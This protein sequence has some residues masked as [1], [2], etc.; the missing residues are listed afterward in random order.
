M[1]VIFLIRLI[2]N[3]NTWVG[4]WNLEILL[5]SLRLT[6]AKLN[7]PNKR[8][9]LDHRWLQPFRL[10]NWDVCQ[11]LLLTCHVCPASSSLPTFPKDLMYF[12]KFSTTSGTTTWEQRKQNLAAC[13]SCELKVIHSLKWISMRS[14]RRV[15]RHQEGFILRTVYWLMWQQA[16]LAFGMFVSRRAEAAGAWQAP[17]QKTRAPLMGLVDYHFPYTSWKQT[18]FCS[19]SINLERSGFIFAS[20]FICPRFVGFRWILRHFYN[21]YYYVFVF[22]LFRAPPS[23]YGG[24]QARGRIRAV[25]AGLRHSHSN[26]QSELCLPPTPQVTATLDP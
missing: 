13:S 3:Q 18:C 22:C 9:N 11:L 6:T 14:L 15:I 25:A 4:P 23:A 5:V 17:R 20:L 7:S 26:A 8:V 21:Y 19:G 1:T 10:S 16:I 24:S 12:W 2:L